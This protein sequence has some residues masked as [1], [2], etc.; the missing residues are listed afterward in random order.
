MIDIA[1]PA[2]SALGCGVS[3][4]FPE[5]PREVFRMMR[6]ARC[7]LALVAS[8][9]CFTLF[10]CGGSTPERD[11]AAP[12]PPTVHALAPSG[13]DGAN[14]LEWPSFG[15]RAIAVLIYRDDNLATPLAIVPGN[16]TSWVDA[17]TPLSTPGAVMESQT[18]TIAIN[19]NTGVLAGPVVPQSTTAQ[20]DLALWPVPAI[21]QTDTTVTITAR[22]VP[23]VPGLVARY[24]L[25]LL[26]EEYH[27]IG[28]TPP[29]PQALSD[30]DTVFLLRLD[31]MS[32]LSISLTFP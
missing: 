28:I 6:S 10:G 21:T 24:A 4:R 16:A 19:E 26:R 12:A 7:A 30:F 32:S 5:S 1:L 15:P 25:R 14:V 29:D 9:A 18:F 17:A 11:P 31:G 22:R 13:P 27:Y 23:P 8:L 2:W 3:A 20:T